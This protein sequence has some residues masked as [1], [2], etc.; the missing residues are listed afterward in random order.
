[1]GTNGPAG[2]LVPMDADLVKFFRVRA[3]DWTRGLSL[4]WVWLLLTGSRSDRMNLFGWF[5]IATT[6]RQCIRPMRQHSI[7]CRAA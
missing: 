7:T 1:M 5:S 3:N 6:I 2:L 4:G